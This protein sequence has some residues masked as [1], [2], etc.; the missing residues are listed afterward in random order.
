MPYFENDRAKLYYRVQGKR[1]TKAPALLF[2]HGWCSNADHWHEQIK[3]FSSQY[4]ILS[5]DRRGLGRSSTPGTGHTP[6]QHSQ[7]IVALLK[8][9]KIRKVIAIGHAGGGPVTLELT[10]SKPNLVK[11]CVMI[12]SGLYPSA[13][14]K[15]RKSPF[16]QLLGGMAD[17]LSGPQGKK[18]FKGMYQGFFG[19]KCDKTVASS[20]VADAM[21]TPLETIIAEVDVMAVNTER[22]ARQIKQP[23]LWLTANAVDQ[24][25]ISKN[26]QNVQF[27]QVVGS[28]HFPQLEVPN[29]TNAAI[30]T[31][32]AQI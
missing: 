24:G 13:N 19:P 23:V 17:R 18:A 27:A 30:E 14:L 7:D 25:Y 31:F 1:V 15:T 9:L 32:L 16:A 21:K 8:H 22:M 12:D 2:I 20:A 29:Q 28:G 5:L 26:V 6:E 10:R 3:H 4:K 11:A